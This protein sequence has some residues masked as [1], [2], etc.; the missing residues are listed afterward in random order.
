MVDRW[1][2]SAEAYSANLLEH[3]DGRGPRFNMQHGRK[4][5]VTRVATFLEGKVDSIHHSCLVT[6]I[7]S[8]F[9]G[10]DP[11]SSLARGSGT[12]K[13][14]FAYSKIPECTTHSTLHLAASLI[15]FPPI[16]LT[17]TS[18]ESPVVLDVA[19]AGGEPALSMAKVRLIIPREGL[20]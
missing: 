15:H 19:A 16:I 17:L 6:F 20:R 18:Q 5:I 1:S 13:F 2:A 10:Q 4:L 9:P 7:F 8:S 14:A 11:T 3:T 12:L